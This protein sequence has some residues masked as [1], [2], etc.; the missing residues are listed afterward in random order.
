MRT[1][2]SLIGALAES[3][4]QGI[5]RCLGTGL[6]PERVKVPARGAEA[7]VALPVTSGGTAC[8]VPEPE[9]FPYVC[10]ICAIGTVRY[11]NGW[12]LFTVSDAFLDLLI[13]SAKDLPLPEGDGGK[14][15]LNRLLLLGRHGGSG[16]PESKTVREALWLCAC[17]AE[18]RTAPAR[19]ERAVLTMFR[20]VPPKQRPALYGLCGEAAL[21]AYRL[22][23][24]GYTVRQD[25]T[26]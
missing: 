21:A 11:E 3:I 20:D 4:A 15:A 8:R 13:A 17:A 2:V 6:P 23:N 26:M 14:L 1:E 16:C 24:F 10:G 12:F 18:G 7:G 22:L 9:D 19:A 5:S 25:R